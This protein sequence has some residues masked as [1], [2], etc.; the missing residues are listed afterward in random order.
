MAPTVGFSSVD[1]RFDKY[2][3]TMFDLG[4]SKKIR[5]IWKNYFAEVYGVIYV[6]DSTEHERLEECSS[7]LK[8]LIEDPKVSGK[9]VLVWVFN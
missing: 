8:N 4:G 1:F 6:I 9:P 5:D 7:V 2:D 3:I